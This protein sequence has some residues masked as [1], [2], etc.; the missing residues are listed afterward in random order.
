MRVDILN[1]DCGH[2]D[3]DAYGQCQPAERH[4]VDG[5][6]RNPQRQHRAHQ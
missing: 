5:L 6:L 4:D 3:E 1:H 2:I